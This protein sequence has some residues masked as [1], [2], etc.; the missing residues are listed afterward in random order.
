MERVFS[1]VPPGAF[2]LQR[3]EGSQPSEKT[4][5]GLGR[6]NMALCGTGFTLNSQISYTLICKGIVLVKYSGN[7]AIVTK[8]LVPKREM[9]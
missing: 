5:V 1:R 3:P 4:V 6:Q 7:L 8:L 9:Y 2:L